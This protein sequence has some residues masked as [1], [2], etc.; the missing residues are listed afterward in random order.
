MNSLKLLTSAAALCT[1]AACQNGQPRV[2]RVAV[3]ITSIKTLQD[4]QCF[5]ANMP[6]TSLTVQEQ[7]YRS[8][9]TWVVWDG[10]GSKQF[11]DMGLS[12]FTLGDSPQVVVDDL[13]EGADRSFTA[14]RVRTLRTNITELEKTIVIANWNDLGATP[15][16]TIVIDAS[17]QCADG[18]TKCPNEP[19]KRSCKQTL[20]F[21]ARKI[22]VSETSEISSAGAGLTVTTR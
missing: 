22:E 8:E 17:Y 5:K 1:L 18:L 21:W 14:T 11:M 15:V 2:Y 7:N 6:P 3:D 10:A 4:P 16:G 9:T 19:N 12:K 13:I 20:N